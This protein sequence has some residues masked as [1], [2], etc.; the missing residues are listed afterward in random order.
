MAIDREDAAVLCQYVE[1]ILL[2]S[3]ATT[4]VELKRGL[5]VATMLRFHHPIS[6]NAKFSISLRA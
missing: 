3:P 5:T 4:K 6:R 1:M 2:V